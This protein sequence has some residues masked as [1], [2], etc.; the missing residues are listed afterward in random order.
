MRDD[1]NCLVSKQASW[2]EMKTSFQMISLAMAVKPMLVDK[3]GIRAA[4]GKL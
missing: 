1:G 2:I 3:T 4:R